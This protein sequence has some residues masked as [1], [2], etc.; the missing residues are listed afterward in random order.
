[1]KKHF[2]TIGLALLLAVFGLTG[3]SC[4]FS[5]NDIQLVNLGEITGHNPSL[6][7]YRVWPIVDAEEFKPESLDVPK[8][9]SESKAGTEEE[10]RNGLREK[11][12]K[13]GDAVSEF[14]KKVSVLGRKI[15]GMLSEMDWENP[16]K[17]RVTLMVLSSELHAIKSAI[18]SSYLHIEKI[19]IVDVRY[20]SDAID[21]SSALLSK[22]FW[23]NILKSAENIQVHLDSYGS[24]ELT[25]EFVEMLGVGGKVFGTCSAYLIKTKAES[26]PVLEYL[27]KGE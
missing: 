1:M 19:S 13:V 16:T 18:V 10:I 22:F 27:S 6:F 8:Q 14:D 26:L 11:M 12:E 2:I 17:E 20:L 7:N 5:K 21:R 24:K 15:S 9:V 4:K 23:P 25:E 3:V